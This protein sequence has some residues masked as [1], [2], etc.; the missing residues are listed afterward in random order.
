MI[1]R[2]FRKHYLTI[3]RLRLDDKYRSTISLNDPSKYWLLPLLER[4]LC[5]GNITTW[6]SG[7]ISIRFSRE[8]YSTWSFSSK[9][10]ASWEVW[11]IPQRASR[12]YWRRDWNLTKL[13]RSSSSLSFKSCK[14]QL[15]NISEK[16]MPKKTNCSRKDEENEKSSP[17]RQQWSATPRTTSRPALAS[18]LIFERNESRKEAKEIDGV[19]DEENPRKRKRVVSSSKMTI[20]NCIT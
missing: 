11:R 17:G 7:I 15:T 4:T 3:L 2:I 13:T 5:T 1:Y 9:T 19:V 16:N 20:K 14:R 6:F 18:K 12:K 10:W 8:F